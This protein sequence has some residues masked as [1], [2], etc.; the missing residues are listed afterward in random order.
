V[1][2]EEDE[3]G[4]EISPLSSSCITVEDETEDNGDDDER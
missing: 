4:E 3:V 1:R 2:E